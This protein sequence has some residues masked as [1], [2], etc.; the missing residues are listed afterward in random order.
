MSTR[1]PLA[2][3]GA[4]IRNGTGEVLLVKS[5]KWPGKWVVMG[6][7]IESGE[8]IAHALIREVKEE[9]G[10]DVQFDRVI[11]VAEFVNTPDFYQPSHL[12]ALQCECHLV[13]SNRVTLDPSELSQFRWFSLSK[14][15][16]LPDLLEVTRHTLTLLQTPAKTTSTS[17]TPARFPLLAPPG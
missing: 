2:V 11:E 9:T 7:K 13:G 6:G 14:A 16:Q 4:F 5:P 8:T 15:L 12:I 10:L 3:V 17:L 1:Y